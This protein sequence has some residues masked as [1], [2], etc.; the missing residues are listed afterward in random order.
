[1]FVASDRIVNALKLAAGAL[2]LM[3]PLFHC[4][5]R[6]AETSTTAGGAGGRDAGVGGSSSSDASSEG[7]E[8]SGACVTWDACFGGGGRGNVCGGVIAD[9]RALWGTGFD[10]FN[11]ARVVSHYGDTV[12]QDGA[13]VLYVGN[14]AGYCN[15]GVTVVY[16]IDVSPNGHCDD[17]VDLVY[18]SNPVPGLTA[19]GEDPGM[20]L[21]RTA[22]D[23]GY[24]LDLAVTPDCFAKCGALRIALLDAGGTPVQLGGNPKPTPIVDMYLDLN[25]DITIGTEPLVLRQ[26]FAGALTPGSDYLVRY[27][28][29]NDPLGGPC[30]GTADRVWEHPLKA[31]AGVNLVTLRAT[32]GAMPGYCF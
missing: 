23:D 10:Q 1:M 26:G 16:R 17:G 3:I 19:T 24:D 30:H 22:F 13:F 31:T 6:D 5:A 11:G 7:R 14:F 9:A 8:G 18:Q 21:D 2:A 12:I 32:P 4:G 25:L 28:W 20:A 15:G 27:Y 29:V